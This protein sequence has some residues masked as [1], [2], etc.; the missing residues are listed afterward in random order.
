LWGYASGDHENNYK[1]FS[2][3]C[4]FLTL[5]SANA[6]VKISFFP[7]VKIVQ[8]YIDTCFLCRSFEMTEPSVVALEM[9]LSG[10]LETGFK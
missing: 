10:Q 4:V 7:N 5:F 2:L 8:A 3:Q 9:N 6:D 1:K